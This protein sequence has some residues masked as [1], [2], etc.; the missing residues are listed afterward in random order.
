MNNLL[1]QSLSI[2][3]VCILALS[4]T[5]CNGNKETK[6]EAN[7]SASSD[8]NEPV[9]L[10]I[11][12]WG[13]QARHDAT[14]KALELYKKK[15][16][17]IT[18]EPEYSGYDGYLD[19][20]STQAAAKNAPDIF[21]LDSPWLSEWNARNQLADLSTINVN[22]LDP[23]LVENGKY[24]GKLTAVPL[25]KNAWG[26]IH[27][28]AALE[29]L[30]ITVP[31]NGMTWNEFFQLAKEIKSKL[32][33]DRY[34]MTDG[35]FN[36]P[37]YAS[38]Q[39]SKGKG[40]PITEEGTFNIDKALWLEWAQI[41]E[42]FRK[43]GIVP[44]ADLQVSDK[45]L[46]P[47]L[48]LMVAGKVLFRFMHAAQVSSWESLKPGSYGVLPTPKD[49]QG[50]GWLKATFYFNVSQDSEHKEEAKKFIDWFVNDPEVAE[51]TGTTRGVPISQK[52]VSL[53]EPKF[54]IGDKMTIE[55][56]NK[57]APDAQKFIPTAKG[58]N[59]YAQEDY[60]DITEALMFGKADAE[61]IFKE[62][63]N[64]AKEYEK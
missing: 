48:D 60:K 10:R 42:D 29:K 14:L 13:A 9:T 12:W 51:I 64:K 55:M 37:L 49:V 41:F 16:P 23:D 35:T 39:L 47:K 32:G 52:I 2:I 24:E 61:T 6:T 28:K 7:D 1:K 58:W 11:M 4:L 8:S 45:E 34:V 62:L 63:Q 26:M 54:S 5:A 15:N 59:N 50:G 30:G 38:Y 56:I 20:L 40:W 21:Q 22:D 57:S 46:D 36:F 33:N 18:F 19:K 3:L 25:G 27:D 43:E 53:L 17:N 31:Q 44:P